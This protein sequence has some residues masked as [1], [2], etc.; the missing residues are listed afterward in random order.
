MTRS[1][2]VMRLRCFIQA[3]V[4]IRDYKV[5]GVQTCAL[6]ILRLFDPVYRMGWRTTSPIAPCK[7]GFCSLPCARVYGKGSHHGDRVRRTYGCAVYGPS[8]SRAAGADGQNARRAADDDE[9]RGK[10]SWFSGGGRWLQ[11]DDGYAKAGRA[12]WGARGVRHGG[13][14]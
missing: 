14:G 2:M 3:E 8:K 5:T 12:F 1:V 4:G 7:R 9:Y 11:T 10:L 6:P 13:K